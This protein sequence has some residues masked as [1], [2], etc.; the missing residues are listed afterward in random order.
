[1]GKEIERIALQR[2]W[3]ILATIDNIKEWEEKAQVLH[4][5]DVIIDFSTPEVVVQNIEK[6]FELSIPIVVGTT[7]WNTEL[8]SLKSKCEQGNHALVFASNFSIGVNIFFEINK[9]LAE[10]MNSHK[11]YKVIIEEIHHKEKLDSPS[12]TAISLSNQI[13]EKVNRKDLMV[14]QRSNKANELS[15]I[16]KRISKVPGTHSIIYSSDIDEIEIKHTAKSRQGFAKGA[17]W[18]AEW[19][20]SKKGFYD[21]NDILFNKL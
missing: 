3:N 11:D 4:N 16:S 1:M 5:G 21:F 12:G 20:L 9:Q 8:P 14:N 15:I 10:L 13:I 7:G 17:V 6:A 18:A 2:G 19:I